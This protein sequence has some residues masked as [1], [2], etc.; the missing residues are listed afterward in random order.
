MTDDILNEFKDVDGLEEIIE[1]IKDLSNSEVHGMLY[2]ASKNKS[3]W[4]F[5]L[6][7]E[8]DEVLQVKYASKILKN[9]IIYRPPKTDVIIGRNFYSSFLLINWVY[10]IYDPETN[11]TG[12]YKQ[13]KILERIMVL[14]DDFDR[15]GSFKEPNEEFYK[16]LKNT[17]WDKEGKTLFWKLKDI[18]YY[19][20]YD[21]W[22]IRRVRTINLTEDHTLIFLAAC[23]TVHRNSD[24]ILPEDIVKAFKTY[25][26][27]LNTDITKLDVLQKDLNQINPESTVGPIETSDEE[28]IK[29]KESLPLESNPQSSNIN[30]INFCPDCGSPIEPQANYCA[31]CGSKLGL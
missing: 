22:G 3:S 30:Q 13:S 25:F 19:V 28:L 12:Y 31:F 5:E 8:V 11:D 6:D 10:W 15:I 29:E 20:D 14:L 24:Q 27:L 1:G 7:D 18:H 9:P 2:K 21:I 26:K 17:K 4:N 16:K 23:N